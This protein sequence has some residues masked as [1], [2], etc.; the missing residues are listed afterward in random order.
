MAVVTPDSDSPPF[1]LWV[2][3]VFNVNL[4]AVGVAGDLLQAHLLAALVAVVVAVLAVVLI[5]TVLGILVLILGVLVLPVRGRRAAGAG[6]V[7]SK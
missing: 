3:I 5:T 2:G 6:W 1:V 7:F 4:D